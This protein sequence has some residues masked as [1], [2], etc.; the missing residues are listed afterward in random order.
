MLLADN[1]YIP[2]ADDEPVFEQRA[3]LSVAT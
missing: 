3:L 2:R 1:P